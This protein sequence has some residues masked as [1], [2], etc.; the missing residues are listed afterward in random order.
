L[1][2]L[3]SA[4]ELSIVPDTTGSEKPAQE[5]PPKASLAGELTDDVVKLAPV[6]EGV[7]TELSR[8]PKAVEKAPHE[9]VKLPATVVKQLP[10]ELGSTEAYVEAKLP[11]IEALPFRQ[12]RPAHRAA[13]G[14]VER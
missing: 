1:L 13:F 9:L 5:L 2:A 11:M 14:L 6:A 4:G 7:E 10:V 3:V 8:L 12:A